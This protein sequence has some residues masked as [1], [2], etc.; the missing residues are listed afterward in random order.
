M[1]DG[2]PSNLPERLLRRQGGRLTQTLLGLMQITVPRTVR[3]G[4]N[5]RLVHKAHGIVIHDA[6]VIGDD[7]TIFQG[8]TIG[9]SDIHRVPIG[10]STTGGVVIGDRVIIGANAVVLFRSGE[11][12]TIGDD[13]VIGAGAVVTKSVE[14]GETWA[15]NPAHRIGVPVGA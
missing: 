7:V 15:G 13:A 9:R 14:P 12:V 4:H 6:T 10:T 3:V 1:A 2:Q 5:L 8:V 11:T